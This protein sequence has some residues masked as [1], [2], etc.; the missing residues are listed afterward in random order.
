VDSNFDRTRTAIAA[1]WTDGDLLRTGIVWTGPTHKARAAVREHAA[2]WRPRAV[3]FD[4]LTSGSIALPEWE[5]VTMRDVASATDLVLQRVRDRSV[6]YRPHAELDDAAAMATLRPIGDGG[7]A[8]RRSGN[9]SAPLLAVAF[10]LLAADRLPATRA[11]IR[12]T[13]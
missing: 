9:A 1:A 7:Q 6:R 2:V 12:G 13:A 11:V 3:R 5:A 4:P 8:F 10:A